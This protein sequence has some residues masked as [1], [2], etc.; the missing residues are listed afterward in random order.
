MELLEVAKSN[1]PPSMWS[2]TPVVLRATAGLR[3]LPREKAEYLLN[4]VRH[5]HDQQTILH[6]VDTLTQTTVA[7][8]SA[9]PPNV[10]K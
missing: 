8:A 5:G 4:T 6:L 7:A 10:Q 3:L 9:L 1:V 2:T